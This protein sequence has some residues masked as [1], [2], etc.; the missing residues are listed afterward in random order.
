MDL[1]DR[2]VIIT[3]AARGLGRAMA[4]EL[5]EAGARIGLIDV[6]ESALTEAAASLPGSGH[7]TA[8]ANVADE[9]AVE[10]AFEQLEHALGGIDG[11]VNNAGITRDA[12]L[13]KARD[14]EVVD[15][16]SVDDWRQVIDVN[17]TGVF[18]C[19]REAAARMIRRGTGGVIN[20]ITRRP[21]N[22]EPAFTTRVGTRFQPLEIDRDTF[23]KE[24]Y[25]D[26]AGRYGRL[27]YFA[28]ASFRRLERAYDAEGD[29]IPDD[30]TEFNDDILNLNGNFGFLI[31]EDQSLRLIANYYR[32]DG[33]E[34][35][36]AAVDAIPGERKAEAVPAET[37]DNF[38]VDGIF[39]DPQTSRNFT[40][41]YSNAD[42]FGSA[43]SAQS[44][45]QRWFNT[46]DEDSTV[47]DCC[48]FAVGTAEREDRRIGVRLNIDTPIGVGPVPGGARVTWGADYLNY[49]SSE[50]VVSDVIGSFVALR[51]DIVQDSIAGFAQVEVPLGDF[52]LSGGVRH[53]HFFVD[54]DDAVLDTSEPGNI[55]TFEGGSL[56]YSSTLFNVGIVYYATYAI[57]L[58][59]G[60]NQGFDVTQIGRAAFQVDSAD[61]I[62][63]EPAVT[64]SY[65]LGMRVFD[66]RWQASLTGFYSTSELASRTINP[67]GTL[68]LA[69]PL[70]QPEQFWGVEATLDIQPFDDWAFGST[71]TWQ[72]GVRETEEDD[73][74]RIQSNL[75]TPVRLT[76]YAEHA[77]FDWLSSR[78]QFSY[79]PGFDRFPG[80]TAFGEGEVDGVFLVDAL[81]TFEVGPG[82]FNVGIENLL[83]NQYI[84][85]RRQAANS[86]DEYF[87]A[88]GLTAALSYQIDW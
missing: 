17:L 34:R 5:A 3:G 77:P 60:F 7:A 85:V 81:A 39:N 83:N 88:P 4:A 86:P 82:Q 21:E 54:V 49:Y 64:D 19:G 84:P 61:Q 27:D 59:A 63:P 56:D 45:Y 79:T 69:I 41:D 58:F 24:I 26:I 67:G 31:D 80:S 47:F 73:A 50:G 28:G 65:E 8:V 40:L 20:I 48:P 6:D 12:L 18:L 74:V 43:I 46:Y 44:F 1:S 72:D 36:L 23:T 14:G 13:V 2:N 75:L 52:L 51:P 87:A 55:Q 38:V 16:M 9:E 42:L 11:L 76:G 29:V 62:E 10:V 57:E 37:I 32:D 35:Q 70:R 15:R 66:D 53:E 22:E 78:L 25:Q 68:A 30:N 33:R 71:F